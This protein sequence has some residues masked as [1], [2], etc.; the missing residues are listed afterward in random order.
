L[1]LPQICP[2]PDLEGPVFFGDEHRSQVLS[3]TFMIKD[4]IA[5]GQKRKYSVIVVMMDKTF[6]LNS[7]PFLV[8][9]IRLIADDLKRKSD[10]V[11]QDELTHLP[12]R[13]QRPKACPLAPMTTDASYRLQRGAGKN[14]MTRSLTEL[15]GDE[16]VYNRLHSA[17]TWLL[18]AGGMRLTERL[19]EGPPTEGCVLDVSRLEGQT[20]VFV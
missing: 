17:F 19:L 6:L 9:H 18:K 3:Y 16:L 20:F 4:A 8:K 13:V 7:W 14:K 1:I 2:D 12:S 15:T 10:A 5:R 11:F